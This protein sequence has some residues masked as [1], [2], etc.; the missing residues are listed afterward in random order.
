[1]LQSLHSL[2]PS[3]QGQDLHSADGLGATVGPP[4]QSHHHRARFI[5]RCARSPQLPCHARHPPQRVRL[6]DWISPRRVRREMDASARARGFGGG[7]GG[8]ARRC[9]VRK[10]AWEARPERGGGAGVRGGERGG[11]GAGRDRWEQ[12]P[13]RSR[14]RGPHL[15]PALTPAPLLPACPLRSG[16]TRLIEPSVSCPLLTHRLALLCVDAH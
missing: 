9:A 1:M 12:A 8:C 5:G 16:S 2:H 14:G 4:H 11:P 7:E 3:T 15:S 6:R 10:A 13:P